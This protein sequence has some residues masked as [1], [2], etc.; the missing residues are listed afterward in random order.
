[1][2]LCTTHAAEIMSSTFSGDD[3]IVLKKI[4][5]YQKNFRTLVEHAIG[6]YYSD[7]SGITS[8]MSVL[9]VTRHVSRTL[10]HTV[11]WPSL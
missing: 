11:A 5:K 1:M 2:K 6:G 9:T 3:L 4:L 10:S 8:F 7:G